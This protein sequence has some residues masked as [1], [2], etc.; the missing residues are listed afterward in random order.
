[1]DQKTA[2]L[3]WLED[4]QVFAVNRLAA[5]SDHCYYETEAEALKGIMGLR[6]AL[7]GIWKFSYAENPAVRKEHFYENDFNLDSF[8]TIEV[9]GHMELQGYAD[10]SIL[11]PC[12]HGMVWLISGLPILTG[13]IIPWEA[14]AGSLNWRS[15]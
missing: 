9:P 15:R 2:K 12:T 1:M 8:G 6:Q 5:H 7:N 4:P 3:E 10:A 13:R 11:I 14:I